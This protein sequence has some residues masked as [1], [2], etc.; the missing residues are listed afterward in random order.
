MRP[1]NAKT[2]TNPFPD[3]PDTTSA[4]GTQAPRTS[5]LT[6]T[7]SPHRTFKWAQHPHGAGD[8]SGARPQTNTTGHLAEGIPA[9]PVSPQQA[10][11]P[12]GPSSNC[13]KL[14]PNVPPARRRRDSDRSTTPEPNPRGQGPR[15]PGTR[16]IL[17][18]VKPNHRT[19][20][21]RVHH[22]TEP[23]SNLRTRVAGYPHPGGQPAGTAKLAR[24]SLHA[25]VDSPH[26]TTECTRT[27]GSPET[28]IRDHLAVPGMISASDSD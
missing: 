19:T 17:P 3:L 5:R 6:A 9:A 28:R 18:Q 4:A 12:T 22:G 23:A 2:P 24:R 26:A 7:R 1:G 14:S 11:A 15:D 21:P 20:R 27:S 8:P 10:S 25:A 16:L 13:R